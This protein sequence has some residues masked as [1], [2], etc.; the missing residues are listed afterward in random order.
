MRPRPPSEDL[1]TSGAT[2]VDA[3]AD[4]ILRYLH[5]HGHAA[6]TPEG[7]ARW[8][9]KRQRL[10]DSLVRVQRALDLL[11][12]RSLVDVRRTPAGVTLY[13]RHPDADRQTEPTAATDPVG[14]AGTRDD[15]GAGI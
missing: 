5:G 4:E 12:S 9:I 15:A 1:C 7:I 3:L 13:F 10:E 2:D 8:W 14:G 6:D 11:V